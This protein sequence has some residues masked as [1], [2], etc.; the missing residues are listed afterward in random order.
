LLAIGDAVVV[1]DERVRSEALGLP[2]HGSW[3]GVIITS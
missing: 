2:V 1:A 3:V